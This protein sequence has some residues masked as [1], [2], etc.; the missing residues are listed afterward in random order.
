MKPVRTPRSSRPAMPT[1]R[2]L[3]AASGAAARDE[4]IERLRASQQPDQQNFDDADLSATPAPKSSSSSSRLTPEQVVALVQQMRQQLSS[5]V[6]PPVI[7][8]PSPVP[9]P[10]T[11]LPSIVS[12]SSRQQHHTQY[13]ASNA[14]SIRTDIDLHTGQHGVQSHDHSNTD[15]GE[16]VQ[17]T[18]SS[19]A[20]VFSIPS[21]AV[22]S[23][24]RQHSNEVAELR[25]ALLSLTGKLQQVAHERDVERQE[26]ERLQ[27]MQSTTQVYNKHM[28]SNSD[29]QSMKHES[30]HS[31]PF[32]SLSPFGSPVLT[33]MSSN[34]Q[35]KK[36]ESDD[37][38]Y[39]DESTDIKKPVNIKQ[40]HK[41]SDLPDIAEDPISIH[42]D[43]EDDDDDAVSVR[44]RRQDPLIRIAEHVDEDHLDSYPE[45]TLQR[46]RL[47][48]YSS[49]DHRQLYMIRHTLLSAQG[50]RLEW[51]RTAIHTRFHP[52]LFGQTARQWF[53][54]AMQTLGV[55]LLPSTRKH[56]AIDLSVQPPISIPDM[57]Y[58]PRD[59]VVVEADDDD[60]DLPSDSHTFEKLPLVLRRDPDVHSKAPNHD[61]TLTDLVK[62]YA[63]QLRLKRI[64]QQPATPD[65][66]NGQTV[67]DEESYPC[68]RCKTKKVYGLKVMCDTCETEAAKV[69][70]D[71]VEQSWMPKMEA[72]PSVPAVTVKLEQYNNRQT[73]A[74]SATPAST[75]THM[76][77]KE[78]EEE[79]TI[80]GE[81]SRDRLRNESSSNVDLLEEMTS[82][83][84]SVLSVVFQPHQRPMLRMMV[85]KDL[86]TFRDRNAAVIAAAQSLTKFDGTTSKASKYLQDLC[87]QVQTYQFDAQE[88]VTLLNKTMIDA[89]S[90]WLQTNLAEVFQI[91]DK[92][93]QVLLM[94]FKTHYIGA[95]VIRDIRKQLASTVLTAATPTI[96]DLDTHYASYSGLLTQLRFS[97]RFVDDKEVLTEYF[98]SLPY[99]IRT[100]IGSNFDRLTSINDL[101][102]EA[103]KALVLIGNKVAAKS[104]THLITMNAAPVVEGHADRSNKRRSDRGSSSKISTESSNSKHALCYHCGDKGH[105]TGRCPLRTSS[106][107]TK[108]KAVWAKRNQDRGHD[109][110][111]NLDWYIKED[112][113]YDAK[114]ARSK[115]NRRPDKPKA[116]EV[117]DVDASKASAEEIYDE[118]D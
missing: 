94:R 104:D 99:N 26:V 108:G 107:T 88:I 72:D 46:E 31:L 47:F 32:P 60:N 79:L 78:Q 1:D 73:P 35:M 90:M 42:S 39:N 27:S 16:D 12:G 115:S 45:W 95:H 15:N 24:H 113:K 89:A 59:P 38:K 34:T 49:M 116:K 97:D 83:L 21:S 3:R 117:I 67:D 103:Q 51:M 54:A 6:Q 17:Q 85:R 66:T 25:S 75:R 71:M 118:D 74:P 20:V 44:D 106:Q 68:R 93:M 41:M 58:D 36:Q 63:R 53:E 77:Y 14:P 57:S 5:P 92:P 10:S 29:V 96:K 56:R 87:T 105:Y 62:V 55:S 2:Q 40:A 80:I 111:Y 11:H 43:D 48:P 114:R 50:R 4:H 102:R 98:A 13:L 61:R 23:M 33:S 91:P 70:R 30:A 7:H 65:K 109:F 9:S 101:H 8:L 28:N 37:H 86:V 52:S 18:A 76:T 82:P 81:R 69:K 112:E 110:V 22:E 100:F 64:S 19:G 84:G